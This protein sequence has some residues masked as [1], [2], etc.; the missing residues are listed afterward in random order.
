MS[1]NCVSRVIMIAALLSAVSAQARA[2]VPLGKPSALVDI[3]TITNSTNA[4][5]LYFKFSNNV[6]GIGFLQEK[7]PDVYFDLAALAQ[8]YHIQDYINQVD[9]LEES[10]HV[11]DLL[12][13]F[14]SPISFLLIELDSDLPDMVYLHAIATREDRRLPDMRELRLPDA[15]RFREEIDTFFANYIEFMLQEYLPLDKRRI[16]GEPVSPYEIREL[17]SEGTRLLSEGKRLGVSN[18]LF[19]WLNDIPMDTGLPKAAPTAE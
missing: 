7:Y 18:S 17:L 14:R 2:L 11:I 8:V 16:K 4:I 12:E 10:D 6:T 15:D 1:R 3:F 5:S 9:N 19:A 13:D